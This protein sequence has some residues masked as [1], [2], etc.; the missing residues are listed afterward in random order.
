[1]IFR[2]IL[3]VLCVTVLTAGFAAKGWAAEARGGNAAPRQPALR[4]GKVRKFFPKQ[5]GTAV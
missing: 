5:G 2:T 1:M 4:A 3:A